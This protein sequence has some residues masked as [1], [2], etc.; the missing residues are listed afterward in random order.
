MGLISVWLFAYVFP[1]LAAGMYSKLSPENR[2]G[3]KRDIIVMH[4]ALAF[5]TLASQYFIYHY[6]LPFMSHFEPSSLAIF[7]I[8]AAITYAALG[9]VGLA[10]AFSALLQQA[11]MLS[12]AFLLLTQYPLL[13]VIFLIVPAFVFCHPLFV[14]DARVRITLFAFWGTGSI[15][16]F[17]L[18]YDFW[19]IA[20]AH[21]LL[22]ATLISRGLLYSSSFVQTKP[23]Q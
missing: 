2:E 17:S 15:V 8:A 11:A 18:T 4:A 5:S 19:L 12:I 10:Y 23:P 13:V 9:K 14:D 1:A 20:A 21:T 22:G 7:L 6:H 3:R 16:L